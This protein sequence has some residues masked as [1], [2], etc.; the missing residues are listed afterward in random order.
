MLIPSLT[1]KCILD[2]ALQLLRLPTSQPLVQLINRCV[3]KCVLE[4]SCPLLDS[5]LFTHYKTSC[6]LLFYG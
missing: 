4:N 6:T 3:N 5:L 1:L 2:D